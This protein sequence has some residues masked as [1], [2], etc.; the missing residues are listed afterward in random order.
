M[1]NV[2]QEQSKCAWQQGCITHLTEQLASLQAEVN[3]LKAA[4]ASHVEGALPQTQ[5]CTQWRL[6]LYMYT[7]GVLDCIWKL[8]IFPNIGA[9]TT[10]YMF[11]CIPRKSQTPSL[12]SSQVL[13]ANM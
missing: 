4:Q 11:D 7:V 8:F 12:T 9:I 13:I 3:Q 6:Q 5:V 2:V 1:G 10:L